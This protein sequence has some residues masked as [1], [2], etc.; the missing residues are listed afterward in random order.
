MKRESKYIHPMKKSPLDSKSIHPMN[1][2]STTK[3]RC[4]CVCM[5]VRE[6]KGPKKGSSIK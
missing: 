6:S 5:S 2:E 1:K 4:L 3:Q